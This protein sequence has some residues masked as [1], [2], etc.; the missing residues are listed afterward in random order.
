MQTPE[1]KLFVE[2]GT[3]DLPSL[4]DVYA[5]IERLPKQPSAKVEPFDGL[6]AN[7][8]EAKALVF[9]LMLPLLM[10]GHSIVLE[11]SEE[12][13]YLTVTNIYE[14]MLRLPCA[15]KK[16]LAKAEFDCAK[17]CLYLSLP[18]VKCR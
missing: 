8:Q 1:W 4:R 11:C 10:H 17:R 7:R 2:L 9:V 5:E 6:N 18:L 14:L 15:V 16:E 3:S 13:L 12:Q